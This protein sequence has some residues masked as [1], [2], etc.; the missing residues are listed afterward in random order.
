MICGAC[1]KANLPGGV[2][3][4]YCGTHFFPPALDFEMGVGSEVSGASTP[5]ADAPPAEKRVRTG[6]L[7]GLLTLLIF[8]GKSLFGLLKLG[9]LLLTLG[10]M[11]LF[12]RAESILFGWRL[13]LGFA[14][15]ILIHELGHVVMNWRHGL[16]FSA[17]MF[18]PFFGALI[19]V[20]QFPADPTV[21]AECGA[22]GP[23][24]GLMAAAAC[25]GIG[26]V[27]GERYWFAV[28]FLGF[29]VNL[30]NLIPFWQLD[31]ARIG[32]ALSPG[33]WDFILV[34][35][36]L[37]VIKAPSAVVWMMLVMLFLLR[38]GRAP[39]A[40]YGLA[41]PVVRARM[42]VLFL[43]M[44][45]ALSYGT[46]R[47]R[48]AQ[49]GQPDTPPAR[50]AAVE[51]PP[52]QAAAP[53]RPA[54][55]P[56]KSSLSPDWIQW[57]VRGVLCFLGI[58][59]WVITSLL[60]AGA[61]GKPWGREGAAL[62]AWISGGLLAMLV[63]CQVVPSDRDAWVL[64]GAY[65]AALVA[66]FFYAL[67]RL[68]NTQGRRAR[69]PRYWLTWRCLA[70]AAGGALV[71][72]YWANSLW[73]VGAVA[74]AAAVFYARRPSLLPGLAARVVESL[75]YSGLAIRLRRRALSLRPEPEVTAELWRSQARSYLA[76]GRGEDALGALDALAGVAGA[77]ESGPATTLL[78]G[79]ARAEAFL[80]MERYEEALAECER[81]LRGP[82]SDPVGTW[83]S[84]LVRERLARMSL[85]RDWPDEAR[86]QA[87]CLLRDTP[88]GAAGLARSLTAAGHRLRAAAQI[89][90]GE[91]AEG[92]A[93][94][95]RARRWGREP[96]EEAE[97]ALI[98]TE[99]ALAEGDLSAA[100]KESLAA[101]RRLPDA[102]GVRF[103]R[104]RVLLALGRRADGEAGLR[105]VAAEVPG[106][107]WG[108]R[109]R[110]ALG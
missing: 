40:R 96:A 83:R 6:G 57:V 51:R 16:K 79:A 55:V 39:A 69:L 46:D 34:V 21:E 94:C 76:L 8:A 75:G 98:R 1:G 59:G 103:W 49:P 91:F 32:A 3:C 17:P 48:F 90:M 72:G 30:F 86:A 27:T 47:T 28:A 68:I 41:T 54:S 33:N 50:S 105:G 93:E 77:D 18:I 56:R 62:S 82:L 10:S 45:L 70:W 85:D 88:A 64:V 52:A 74:A 43:G 73:V 14:V 9:P 101:V 65:F 7:V 66:G 20:K 26:V 80:L 84:L 109:A 97:A 11:F 104:G 92:R 81:L 42:A 60:L 53:S 102:L 63:L 61:A 37:V 38:F 31:G 44:C 110:A 106:E 35:L 12:V 25:A 107:V 22:G 2:R 29:A 4:V 58:T 108:G 19:A 36:L 23:A 15:S 13:A 87:D 100:D 95:E 5:A 78:S 89:R 67:Y 99:A 24:A 71:V